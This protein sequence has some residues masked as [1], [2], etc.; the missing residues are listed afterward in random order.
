MSVLGCLATTTNL[1]IALLL[2]ASA[3]SFALHVRNAAAQ[4]KKEPYLRL[5]VARAWVL[6]AMAS[7][8]V[9]QLTGVRGVTVRDFGAAF[10]DSKGWFERLCSSWDMPLSSFFQFLGYT[11]RPEFFSMFACL[12]LTRTLQVNPAWALHVQGKLQHSMDE[13]ARVHGVPKVPALCVEGV[14]RARL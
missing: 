11:G 7:E 14:L 5:W 12:L 6:S 10:P 8:G 9:L 13:C 2:P 3:S 4:K 1:T